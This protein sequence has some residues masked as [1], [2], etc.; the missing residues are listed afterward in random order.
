MRI[1]FCTIPS[2]IIQ[3]NTSSKTIYSIAETINELHSVADSLANG[4][5]LTTNQTSHEF[6]GSTK[7]ASDI[8]KSTSISAHL[9][10]KISP[11][12][13][14]QK[15][16]ENENKLTYDQLLNSTKP[17]HRNSYILQAHHSQSSSSSQNSIKPDNSPQAPSPNSDPIDITKTLTTQNI[18][19]T[20]ATLANF[21]TQNKALLNTLHSALETMDAT[22][23]GLKNKK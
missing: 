18:G 21:L 5:K 2:K 1:R 7:V 11:T 9:S 16:L 8:S 4:G 12:A 14:T 17:Q 15:E 13:T 22:L 6:L 23:A 19:H 10:T 20:N 3:P